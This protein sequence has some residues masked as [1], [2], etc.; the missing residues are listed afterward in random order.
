LCPFPSFSKRDD[1]DDDDDGV[2]VKR[3]VVKQ[4]RQWTC[5]GVDFLLV[6]F[7]SIT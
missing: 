1:D 6:F 7:I 5:A 3:K 4:Y 2:A